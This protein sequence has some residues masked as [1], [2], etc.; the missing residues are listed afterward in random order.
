MD[1]LLCVGLGLFLVFNENGIRVEV[2]ISWEIN[3]ILPECWNQRREQ[4]MKSTVKDYPFKE[5]YIPNARSSFIKT[6]TFRLNILFGWVVCGLSVWAFLWFL[7]K[8]FL[9]IINNALSALWRAYDK[10]YPNERRWKPWIQ[11]S[12]T[13]MH[14]VRRT[15]RSNNIK[16]PPT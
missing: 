16:K 1:S 11:L 6:G 13:Q 15:H 8:L 7:R 14:C 9:S 4:A 2:G 5:Y 12:R 10:R 3:E